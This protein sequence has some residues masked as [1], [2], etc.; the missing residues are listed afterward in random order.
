MRVLG[1]VLCAAGIFL[2]LFAAV[3]VLM[4]V[5]AIRQQE[6]IF[7]LGI[8]LGLIGLAIDRKAR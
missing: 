1:E 5:H 2:V 7:S 4:D 6:A 8:A 3:G